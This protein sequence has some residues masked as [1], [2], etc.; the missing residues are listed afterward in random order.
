MVLV[1]I[2][3]VVHLGIVLCSINGTIRDCV[4][5]EHYACVPRNAPVLRKGS[6]S[7]RMRCS[8]RY[9]LVVPSINRTICY[10][11]QLTLLSPLTRN[12]ILSKVIGYFKVNA[13]KF[14]LA[15]EID[16][17]TCSFQCM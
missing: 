7:H 10:F 17:I 16:P 12:L 15:Q 4:V 13:E 8:S 6:V 5:K 3:C 1:H 11:G 9:Y 2:R 14:I